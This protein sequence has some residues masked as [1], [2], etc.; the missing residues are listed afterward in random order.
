MAL[1]NLSN[2]VH[3]HAEFD[4]NKQDLK[5]LVKITNLIAYRDNS[6]SLAL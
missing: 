6:L 5:K 2:T 4:V 1:K 3:V